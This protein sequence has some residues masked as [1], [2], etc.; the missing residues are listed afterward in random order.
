MTSPARRLNPHAR[1]VLIP[2]DSLCRRRHCCA[3]LRTPGTGPVPPLLTV[4]PPS[5]KQPPTNR[6]RDHDP[7][8]I[9]THFCPSAVDTNPSQMTWPATIRSVIR[10]TDQPPAENPHEHI[11][12]HHPHHRPGAH[13][14]RGGRHRRE[15]RVLLHRRLQ[16]AVLQG[17]RGTARS[18]Q[19][20][21]S[22][23]AHFPSRTKNTSGALRCT[24]MLSHKTQGVQRNTLS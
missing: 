14:Q 1:V 17:W 5:V 16:R 24:F 8:G 4:I 18:H 6:T 7:S 9:K 12:T 11:R 10:C 2:L 15:R 21:D 20:A 23:D 13:L 3:R 19:L 22:L